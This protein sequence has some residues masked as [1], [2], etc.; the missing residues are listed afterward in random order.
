[1]G[2]KLVIIELKITLRYEKKFTF[3]SEGLASAT[4]C[5]SFPKVVFKASMIYLKIEF[6]LVAN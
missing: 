3:L 2:K 1:M 6:V 4:W 5:Q